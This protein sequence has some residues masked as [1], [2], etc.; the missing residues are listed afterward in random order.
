MSNSVFDRLR[1]SELSQFEFRVILPRSKIYFARM[2]VGPS[3]CVPRY[4]KF[5]RHLVDIGN[6]AEK[7][8]IQ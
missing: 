7:E 5:M 4:T 6:H 8:V 2:I 3:A 1:E